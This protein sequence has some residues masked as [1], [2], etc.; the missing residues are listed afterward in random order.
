MRVC[1]APWLNLT[2]HHTGIVTPCCSDLGLTFPLGDLNAQ[3]LKEIWESLRASDLRAMHLTSNLPEMC[4]RCEGKVGYLVEVSELILSL[5][6]FKKF[7]QVKEILENIQEYDEL[8][9]EIETL[10]GDKFQGFIDQY[11]FEKK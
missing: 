2:V 5:F 1:S 11:P 8:I 9:E 10:L 7:H 4:R 3:S 6:N